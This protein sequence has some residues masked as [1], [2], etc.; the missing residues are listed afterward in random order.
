MAIF[1]IEHMEGQE[2]TPEAL[3][4]WI[5]LEYAHMLQ[6][7]AGSISSSQ[8]EHTSSVLFSNLSDHSATYLTKQLDARKAT[9]ATNPHSPYATSTT[10]IEAYLA[11]HDIP[12]S[13]VCLLDPRAPQALSPADAAHF[14]VFLFG[15]ILGNDPPLDRTGELRRLGFPGRHLRE[16]QMTT[17]TAVGVTKLCVED[18]LTLDQIPFIDH[19]TIEFNQHES[20]EMPFRYIVQ[21]DNGG[22]LMP[23]GMKDCLY[24]DMNKSFDF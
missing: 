13:K 5:V 10:K 18:G 24:E 20:T 3:P 7:V 8:R 11:D 14:D 1:A 16:I 6:L 21:K 15:G 22:P 4:I 19:P 9:D 2:S 17:D 23:T 12:K